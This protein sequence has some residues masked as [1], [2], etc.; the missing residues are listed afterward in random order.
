[1]NIFQNIYF[2]KRYVYIHPILSKAKQTL[3]GFPITLSKAV[4]IVFS[5]QVAQDIIV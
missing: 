1:M 3:S 2:N 5:Q 4:Y